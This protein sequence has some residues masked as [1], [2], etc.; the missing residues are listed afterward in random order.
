MQSIT[1]CNIKCTRT[2]SH[3]KHCN[4]KGQNHKHHYSYIIPTLSFRSVPRKKRAK[5]CYEHHC[6]FQ[7]STKQNI[8]SRNIAVHEC[9]IFQN[10]VIKNVDDFYVQI[11]IFFKGTPFYNTDARE[12]K[13]RLSKHM[14]HTNFLLSTKWL[15]PSCHRNHLSTV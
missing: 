4:T 9:S 12:K 7:L 3:N 13:S 11:Y 1:T 14:V 10:T 8:K 15:S 5:C 6:W 2:N